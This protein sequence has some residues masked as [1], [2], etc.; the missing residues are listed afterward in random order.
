MDGQLRGAHS[1]AFMKTAFMDITEQYVAN[2]K[3]TVMKKSRIHQFIRHDSR[4]LHSSAGLGWSG[5]YL[6]Q[7]QF[8]PGEKPKGEIDGLLLC[9][10]NN[11]TPTRSDHP[12]AKGRFVPK[13][14]PPGAFSL[15]TA[16]PLAPVRLTSTTSG[17]LV[18]LDEAVMAEV[19]Q[20]IR[21]EGNIYSIADGVVVQDKRCFLDNQ[22]RQILED[23]SGEARNASP[24]GR[25]YVDECLQRSTSIFFSGGTAGIEAD[26]G[27]T[28]WIAGSSS[29]CRSVYCPHPL[30]N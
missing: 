15:Y 29:A 12:D 22:I 3:P 9:L 17:L 27:D 4:P 2:P 23:L 18:V 8:D 1:I 21:E 20:H 28:S 26:G 7:H 10:W 14:I 16:G 19:A 6:E 5:I 25:L 13:L 24:H 11:R 30:A